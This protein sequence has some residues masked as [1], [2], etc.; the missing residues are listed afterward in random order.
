MTIQKVN[1]TT[2]ETETQRPTEKAPPI[3]D[4]EALA[5]A[6]GLADAVAIKQ[7]MDA[8]KPAP[9]QW[10]WTQIIKYSAYTA[11]VGA[12]G[13]YGYTQLWDI[14]RKINPV[15]KTAAQIIKKSTPNTL[16]TIDTAMNGV[17][18]TAEK[19]G[20]AISSVRNML[21]GLGVTTPSMPKT[22]AEN[23]QIGLQAGVNYAVLGTGAKVAAAIL[24]P[25]L[26]ATKFIGP[27]NPDLVTA[28]VATVA[29]LEAAAPGLPGNLTQ[30]AVDNAENLV[31]MVG[32]GFTA[33]RFK[34]HL[35][36]MVTSVAGLCAAATRRVFLCKR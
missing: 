30:K 15:A 5:Y 10:T 21:N 35:I 33:Y 27:L 8:R 13:Y 2:P 17:Q 9:S 24:N 36:T 23:A 7:M 12:L 4:N 34:A 32:L 16:A 26:V 28:T 20:G 1:L 29:M 19:F 25:A 3:S 22:P 31:P 6:R 14:A 18:Q 11:G